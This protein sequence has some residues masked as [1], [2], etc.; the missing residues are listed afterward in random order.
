MAL[1]GAFLPQ[2]IGLWL[3]AGALIVAALWSVAESYVLYRDE[4]RQAH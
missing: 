1:V 4:R 3:A 2:G